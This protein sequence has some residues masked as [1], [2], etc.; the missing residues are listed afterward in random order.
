MNL[1]LTLPLLLLVSNITLSQELNI[2]GVFTGS[3]VY[4]LNPFTK[5]DNQFSIQA[6]SINEV[7]YR[8]ETKSSAFEIDL[9]KMG[10]KIGAELNFRIKYKDSA[11]PSIINTEDIEAISSFKIENAF[12]DKL[13]YLK[14]QSSNETG[15][16]PFYIQQYRWNKWITIGQM[17]GVGT[18]GINHYKIKIQAH[19]GDNIYRIH[20]IDNN[21]KTRYSD[22]IHYKSTIKPVYL[23]SGKVKSNLEFSAPTQFEIFDSFGNIIFDGYSKQVRLD[24]LI[25]GKYYINFDN[26]IGEF[27]KE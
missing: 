19:S 13:Q 1:K 3:N 9:K 5:S 6:I 24:N 11:I 4:I 25:I 22:T 20:Q 15:S 10:F 18:S 23:V 16:L 27:I 14:W 8:D 21:E 7:D 17:K 2:K 12:V 26:T